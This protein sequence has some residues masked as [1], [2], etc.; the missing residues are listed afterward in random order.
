[1]SLDR[2]SRGK[3]REKNGLSPVDCKGAE[4]GKGGWKKGGLGLVLR[5]RATHGTLKIGC[6]N[7]RDQ[8]LAKKKTSPNSGQV[9]TTPGGETVPCNGNQRVGGNRSGEEKEIPKIR[10]PE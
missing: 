8:S 7:S 6:N 2:L 1:M 5:R 10:K 3:K 9:G 4:I